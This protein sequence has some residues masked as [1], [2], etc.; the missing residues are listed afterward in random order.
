M[1]CSERH[2]P[3]D[4]TST[5][6]KALLFGLVL[7]IFAA[8]ASSFF[9][10]TSISAPAVNTHSA[11]AQDINRAGVLDLVKIATLEP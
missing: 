11:N 9:A 6:I 7:V 1:N 5:Q 2:R 4:K 10:Y 3:T 8:E